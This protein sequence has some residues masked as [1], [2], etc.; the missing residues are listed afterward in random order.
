M[1][2]ALLEEFVRVRHQ[3]PQV[4][5]VLADQIDGGRQPARGSRSRS[6]QSALPRRSPAETPSRAPTAR[7]RPR[8]ENGATRSPTTHSGAPATARRIAEHLLDEPVLARAR[9]PGSRH[10]RQRTGRAR[11]SPRRR[12]PPHV[13]RREERVGADDEV[14][15]LA[16]ARR[17]HGVRRA[18]GRRLPRVAHFKPKLAAVA[19]EPLDLLCEMAGDDR[20]RLEPAVGELVQERARSPAGRRSAAR[21]SAQRSVSGRSRVPEPGGD[22][23]SRPDHVQSERS[24]ERGRAPGPAPRGCGGSP[25][26]RTQLGA[27]AG[28][29]LGAR[30]RAARTAAS[31][32]ASVNELPSSLSSARISSR[33]SSGVALALTAR[34]WSARNSASSRRAA[35]ASRRGSRVR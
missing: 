5:E 32:S 6:P 4:G 30:G 19:A 18:V 28:R 35:P 11:R 1:R 21:A 34:P 15:R 7:S 10:D 33:S 22:H 16:P 26:K 25:Q 3:L 29:R 12:E 27:G 9:C 8:L 23:D 2:P 31:A 17:E 14:R 24:G 13:T 20:D